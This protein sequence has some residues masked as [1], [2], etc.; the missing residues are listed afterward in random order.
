M[1][2]L[3]AACV[4]CTPLLG[5]PGDWREVELFPGAWLDLA[6]GRVTGSEEGP[7]LLWTERGLESR[8]PLSLWRVG[9]QPFSH[10]LERGEGRL[11]DAPWL[12]GWGDE[13]LFDLGEQGWGYLGVR[14]LEGGRLLLEWART[15]GAELDRRPAELQADSEGAAVRLGWPAE[16]GATYQVERRRVG[17][18]GPWVA[19]G[20]VS[21]GSFLDDDPLPGL[22][23]YRV[24]LEDGSTAFGSSAR[25]LRRRLDPDTPLELHVGQRIDLLE[26]TAGGE[27][28]AGDLPDL[29]VSGLQATWIRLTLL[30]GTRI[31]SLPR[32]RHPSWQL[33]PFDGSS[34]SRDSTT[35]MLGT[36]AA[37]HLSEGVYGRLTFEGD[38]KGGATLSWTINPSGGR[39][40][41]LPPGEA[42]FQW[43]A[44]EVTLD[45]TDPPPD[46]PHP[47]SLH[48]VVERE[49]GYRTGVWREVARGAPGASSLTFPLPR[50]GGAAPIA[51]LRLR[52]SLEGACRSIP[53]RPTLV[54]L[55]ELEDQRQVEALLERAF[56][57]L[58]DPDYE[59]RLAAR[60]LIGCLGAAAAPRLERALRSEN[61]ELAAAAREILIAAASEDGGYIE[62]LLRARAIAEGVTTQPPAG[63]FDV[64]PSYRAWALVRTRDRQGTLE[65]AQLLAAADPDEGVALFAGGLTLGESGEGEPYALGH[66][67]ERRRFVPTDW[68]GLAG[69]FSPH[70]V[71]ELA[72]QEADL[73]LP[74]RALIFYQVAAEVEARGGAPRRWSERPGLADRIE[75]ALRLA[76]REGPEG[77]VLFDA[78]ASL[79]EDRSAWVEARLELL[80]KRL[81]SEEPPP[82][83]RR[84][85]IEG[86]FDA[87]TGALASL[88]T[89]GATG[90]DLVLGAGDWEAP[91]LANWIELAIPGLRLMS[92][93]GARL[94]ANLRVS[95]ASDIVLQGLDI[96]SR[97]GPALVVDGGSVTVVDC[98]LAGAQTTVLVQGGLLELDRCLLEAAPETVP[99]WSLRLLAGATV[100]ARGTLLAAG[101][102][103]DAPGGEIVL[104]HCVLDVGARSAVQGQRGDR[105]LLKG[106]LLRGEGEG[107]S[108]VGEGL[109]LDVVF[110]TAQ[111][112]VSRT[113]GL[114]VVPLRSARTSRTPAFP[115]GVELTEP[116]FER[117]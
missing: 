31:F 5:Q 28:D 73:D 40:L 71:A 82:P 55:G 1:R 10:H 100:L 21:A 4:L 93:E 66:T 52:Y 67:R 25:L 86:G 79:L 115:S 106:C 16:A 43:H 36:S 97:Q 116:L 14:R 105:V 15:D 30:G 34:Y 42:R 74:H 91:E 80:Q 95:N 9:A 70:E 102:L 8:R 3:W 96:E 68:R 107:I 84:I 23:E 19:L 111:D 110:D 35:L 94:R 65:W 41:P 47:E 99:Q 85:E 92:E 51:H 22:S 18:E 58:V 12:P 6:S 49:E 24:W 33:P 83:R 89:Q 109:A 98:R 7:S 112:P 50:D 59:R 53:G 17:G 69:E 13:Y 48:I 117:R 104:D 20:S 113:G 60:S 87:L 2:K 38:G 61:P 44:G 63:I 77:G 108:R 72:R 114:H 64:R 32:G 37:V 56:T 88:G 45:L 62:L 29:A 101:S 46:L 26:G 81:G 75:L 90:V 11:L 76:Q 39:V 78:A 27:V 54:V 57:D 103:A